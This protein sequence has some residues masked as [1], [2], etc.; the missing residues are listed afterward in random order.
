MLKKESRRQ[1][2]DFENRDDYRRFQELLMGLDVKLQLQVPVQTIMAKRY[3]ESRPSKLS[4]LQYLRLWQSAGRQTLMFFANV[5]SSEYKEYGMDNLRPVESKSKTMIRLDVHLPGRVRRRSGSKSPLVIAKPSAQE[6]AKF[7][8][9]TD[10]SD[11]VDFDYVEIEFSSAEDRISF[12]SEARF[13]RL[14]EE[15]VASP[16]AFH[17]GSPSS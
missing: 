10:V 16:F 7:V 3:E 14:P 4:S 13:H 12:L 11:L 15:P 1:E 17:A 8:E 6:Q 9:Q 2:Y 5:S